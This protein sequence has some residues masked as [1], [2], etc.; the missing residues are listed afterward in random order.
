LASSLSLYPNPAADRAQLS[1]DASLNVENVAVYS[2]TGQ[3]LIDLQPNTNNAEITGLESGAYLVRVSSKT[4][5]KTL[6]LIIE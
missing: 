4:A 1:W 3:K 6:R 2:I 5:T